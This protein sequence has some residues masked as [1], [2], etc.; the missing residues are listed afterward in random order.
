MI[1]CEA[2]AIYGVI[3]AIILMG[4]IVYPNGWEEYLGKKALNPGPYK[5]A[6]FGG[7]C[8]FMSGMSVG[9]CNLFCG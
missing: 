8:I 9:L 1:F 6:Q 4:K 5:I 7:Y 2:V 3:M